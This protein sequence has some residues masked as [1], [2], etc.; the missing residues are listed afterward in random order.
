VYPIWKKEGKNLTP[1]TSTI[2]GKKSKN[3]LCS[4]TNL[5]K[6]IART[7]ISKILYIPVL[8][9]LTKKCEVSKKPDS[10]YEL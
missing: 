10:S 7:K 2:S 5:K 8:N 3:R 1:C 4:F 9:Y 6:D